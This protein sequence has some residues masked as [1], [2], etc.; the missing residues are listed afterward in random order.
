MSLKKPAKE[1]QALLARTLTLSLLL[2]AWVLKDFA[3]LPFELKNDFWQLLSRTAK[4]FKTCGRMNV[5][6]QKL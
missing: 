3:L 5:S 6:V 1:Q 2:L 4:N